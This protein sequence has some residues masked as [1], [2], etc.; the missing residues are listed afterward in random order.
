MTR[1]WLA[2]ITLFTLPTLAGADPGQDW[3]GGYD[4]MMWGAG[5]NAHRASPDPRG[6]NTSGLTLNFRSFGG[7]RP[8]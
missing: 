2:T 3:P 7:A 6:G 1:I 8:V 5:G 4:H